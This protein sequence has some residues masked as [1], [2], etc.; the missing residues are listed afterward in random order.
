M[1]IPTLPTI[2]RLCGEQIDEKAITNRVLEVPWGLFENYSRSER[3]VRVVVTRQMVD[4]MK[5]TKSRFGNEFE[6]DHERRA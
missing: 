4:G 5:E 2:P 1:N 3:R 6:F